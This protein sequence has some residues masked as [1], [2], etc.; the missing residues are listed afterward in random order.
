MSKTVTTRF[1]QFLP[2][3][4]RDSAG[5]P[6][7]GKTRVV[8]KLDITSYS[9]GEGEPVS[10]RDLGLTNIDAVSF[11]VEEEIAGALTGGDAAR[12]QASYAKGSGHLYLYTVDGAGTISPVATSGT[13]SVEFVAEGDSAEDVELI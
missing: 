12:R 2:G 3:A 10:A 5:N 4:G 11:R 8:G 1:K 9:G 13:E 6:V 7:Q